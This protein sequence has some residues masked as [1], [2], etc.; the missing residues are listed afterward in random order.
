MSP[1]SGTIAL[2]SRFMLLDKKKSEMLPYSNV[3]FPSLLEVSVHRLKLY[4]SILFILG[5][6]FSAIPTSHAARPD[7]EVFSAI[8]TARKLINPK[9]S[10]TADE[11]EECF[12]DSLAILAKNWDRLPAIYQREFQ[13]IF[14]RPGQPG[15]AYAS[16]HLPR[17]FDTPH[18]RL[19]YTEVGTHAPPLEDIAP[20][21][22][23]PDYVEICAEA[24][25]RSFHVQVELMGF[26]KPLDDFWVED[27]GGNHKYDVYLFMFPALGF[28][29]GDW[30]SG[31]VLSTVATLGPYFAIN[32]RLYNYFG[33]SES[34][35]FIQTTSAH[36]FL[37]GIQGAYNWFMPTWFM[38]ASATWIESIVYDGGRIDDGD[39]IPDPDEIGETDAYNYYAHQLRR[40]FLQ[41]DISLDSRI[42]DHEYGSVIWTL[43]MTERFDTDIV[44]QF[45]AN[46]TE[47]SYRELANFSQVFIDYGSNLAEAFKTFTVWNYFTYNRD[48]GKHYFNGHRLPPVAIHPNDIHHAYPLRV[49]FDSESMPEHFS[50]RYIVFEPPPGGMEEFAVKIDGADLAPIDMAML[51]ANDQ[52]AIQGELNR[53]IFTGLRGWGAK[54]IVHGQ[55]GTTT[56]REGFTY[57]RS[58]ET[59][60]TFKDF[61]GEIQRIVLVLINMQPDVEHVIVPGGGYF[62]GSVS[63][64]AGAPP[65]GKLS[66]P[67]VFQGDNG[68][69]LEWEIEDLTGIRDVVIVRKRYTSLIDTDDDMPFQSAVEVFGAAD[70][71]SNG[72]P[73]DDINIVGRVRATDTYFEDRTIF[74]DTDVESRYFEIDNTRYYYAVV[75]VSDAGIMGTPSIDAHGIS[76][77]FSAVSQ[78]PAFIINTQQGV[79]GEWNV[80]VSGTQE[81]PAAPLLTARLPDGSVHPV[82]LSRNSSA[83]WS[84]TLMLNGFP[85]SGIYTYHIVGK[86]DS[87]T[88]GTQILKGHTFHYVPQSAERN[89]AVAP[90]PLYASRDDCIYFYPRGMKVRIYDSHGGLVKVI[91]SASQWDCTNQRGEKMPSGIYYFYAEDGQGF[92]DQGKIGIMR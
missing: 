49:D 45:Y 36:E 28:A 5:I 57:Q 33:K 37:H 88:A 44:R 84:G 23:V 83:R 87:G 61:G 69:R 31:R 39:N 56:I 25:E 6:L 73:E 80:E 27:N 86:T 68:V 63:Y 21:N 50:S 35:R 29:T 75:P 71:D 3:M 59:Q 18:F 34:I 40:W 24:M 79:I 9:P 64:M 20:M 85:P 10:Y 78:A 92:H 30:Y 54:F 77:S 74:Q 1:K 41:P 90:N 19:H 15:S 22:G 70:R 72:I 7:F 60:L 12:T 51:N 58:Q 67:V 46:T 2:R 82:N 91:D 17:K 14:L 81:L 32:S 11:I 53:H 43:Y 42:L 4:F 38:E 13:G 55:N 48:D 76:P 8:R 16:V 47:G 52:V 26:K 65:R 62:G 66:T 89:L